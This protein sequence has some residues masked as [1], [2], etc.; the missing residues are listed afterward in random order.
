M[1]K[2]IDDKIIFFHLVFYKNIKM[3]EIKVAALNG[4]KMV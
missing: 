1:M 4:L 3:Q 2:V